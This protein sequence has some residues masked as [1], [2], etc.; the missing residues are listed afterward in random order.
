[1][2]M[3]SKNLRMD[4]T[5]Q[6]LYNMVIKKQHQQQQFAAAAEVV[7]MMRPEKYI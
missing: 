2:G 4:N 7:V 5:N 3:P 6:L 1:M